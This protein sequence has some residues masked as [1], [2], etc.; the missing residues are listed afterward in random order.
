MMELEEML[1]HMSDDY[2]VVE[3]PDDWYYEKVDE[4]V[5]KLNRNKL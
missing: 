2:C 1:E 5:Y 4:L 3:V